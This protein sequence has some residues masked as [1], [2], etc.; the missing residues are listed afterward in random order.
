MFSYVVLYVIVKHQLLHFTYQATIIGSLTS[1]T[2][3]TLPSLYLSVSAAM[4]FLCSRK[5]VDGHIL[6]RSY[7]V[8]IG[9]HHF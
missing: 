7:G 1:H 3:L 4:S 9:T 5:F 2:V 8:D 6:P